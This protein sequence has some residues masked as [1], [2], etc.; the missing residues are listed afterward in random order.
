[1]KNVEGLHRNVRAPGH[2]EMDYEQLN[3]V[4]QA[5]SYDRPADHSVP[6]VVEVVLLVPE[7][8]ILLSGQ[9]GYPATIS[10][11]LAAEYH[12]LPKEIEIVSGVHM[13]ENNV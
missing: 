12:P 2:I 13:V 7:V 1:M 8:R 3:A 5:E 9:A 6:V 4:H 11:Y 10:R